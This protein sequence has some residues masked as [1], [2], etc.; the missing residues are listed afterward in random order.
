M[1]MAIVLI[2]EVGRP[3]LAV[4]DSISWVDPT[5][6]EWRKVAVSSVPV[7][8]PKPAERQV[9]FFSLLLTVDATGVSDLML[10]IWN[11]KLNKRFLTPVAF[12]QG[13]FY[14]SNR[15]ES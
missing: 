11:C 10:V 14:L 15:S 3:T 1:A 4:G 5:M 2:T 12:Y 13:S 8:E 6:Q 9:C 7:I